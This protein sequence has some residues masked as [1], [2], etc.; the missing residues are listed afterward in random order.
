[1]L[2][3]SHAWY[4]FLIL[5]P[6]LQYLLLTQKEIQ[7]TSPF[8][9]DSFTVN[10]RFRFVLGPYVVSLRSPHCGQN[11]VLTITEPYKF[12]LSPTGLIDRT[13]PYILTTLYSPFIPSV[14]PQD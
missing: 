12:F 13:T 14:H 2:V 4:F 5:L 11:S 8:G 7:P 1:M 9:K 6:L 3:D 10:S